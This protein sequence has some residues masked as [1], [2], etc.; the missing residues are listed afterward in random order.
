MIDQGPAEALSATFGPE[1]L[2]A[3]T[4][5][6]EGLFQR[7]LLPHLLDNQRT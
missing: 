6:R 1:W 2:A 3:A 5:G 7:M 4:P